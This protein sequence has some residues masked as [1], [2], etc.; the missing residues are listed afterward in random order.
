M[1]AQPRISRIRA[2]VI[3]T[4]GLVLAGAVVGA[5]WAWLAPPIHGVIA[6]TKSGD[7]VQAYLG[8]ESDNF[9]VA[10]FLM[11][12]LLS[13]VG[14]IAAV[15]VWQWRAHRGPLLAAA[16]TLGSVASGAVATAIGAVLVRERYDVIDID[17]APVTPEHRVHY[18]TEAP[19]VFFG[20]SP[21]QI[22][23]TLLLPAAAAAAVYALMA[24]STPRDDLAGYPPVEHP[25]LMW[26]PVQGV[27]DPGVPAPSGTAPVRAEGDSAAAPSPPG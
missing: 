27:T 10:A 20:H 17:G 11:A 2:G 26:N 6:L 16:L 13:V 3:V 8:A 22:A 21:A 24:L 14:I 18:I 5:L 9:F 23:A 15:L 19:S 25:L 7:R 1:N 12:G 4:V